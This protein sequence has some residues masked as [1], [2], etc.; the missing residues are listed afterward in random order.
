MEQAE[1]KGVKLE[2]FQALEKERLEW[3]GDMDGR[4]EH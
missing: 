1:L 3:E 2:M 4:A